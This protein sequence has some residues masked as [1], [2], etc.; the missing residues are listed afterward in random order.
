[1]Q[2]PRSS[3]DAHRRSGAGRRSL[4]SVLAAH[5]RTQSGQVSCL[6]YRA[7]RTSDRQGSPES[8]RKS[9]AR[10]VSQKYNQLTASG[11]SAP[12]RSKAGS[13]ANNKVSTPRGPNLDRANC[14]SAAPDDQ[15]GPPHPDQ[16]NER[17]DPD[18]SSSE[19]GANAPAVLAIFKSD[20]CANEGIFP[21]P[22]RDEKAPH[23]LA[24]PVQIIGKTVNNSETSCSR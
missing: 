16:T 21:L 7:C 12:D 4:G 8:R 6:R 13:C 9:A 24:I 1:V 23:P 3:P 15:A 10:N 11:S 22:A 14:R 2:L 20:D 18:R 17:T 19:N 5:G